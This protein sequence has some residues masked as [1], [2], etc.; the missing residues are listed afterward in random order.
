MSCLPSTRNMEPET[1]NTRANALSHLALGTVQ[2]GLPYGV[3]N[4]SGQPPAKTAAAAAADLLGEADLVIDGG[5]TDGVASTIVSLLEA[6]S[7]ILR[8]GAISLE[9]IKTVLGEA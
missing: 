4:R 9:Q 6:A 2:F 8:P 1:R 5:C 3:A 7:K